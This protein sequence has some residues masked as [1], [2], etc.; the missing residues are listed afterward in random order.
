MNYRMDIGM[1]YA[2]RLLILLLKPRFSSASV[3]HIHL[4]TGSILAHDTQLA[5]VALRHRGLEITLENN[6]SS[7]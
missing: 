4:H 5:I 2:G 3:I 6:Y 1:T 7:Y